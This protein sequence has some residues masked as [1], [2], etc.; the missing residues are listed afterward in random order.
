MSTVVRGTRSKLDYRDREK[1]LLPSRSEWEAWDR[2]MRKMSH[3]GE[4]G[5]ESKSQGSK[6][7]LKVMKKRDLKMRKPWQKCEIRAEKYSKEAGAL[8]SCFPNYALSGDGE[9]KWSERRGAGGP[10]ELQLTQP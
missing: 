2:L 6:K 10:T 5:R 3:Q 1:Q 7:R 4:G 8:N 9:S